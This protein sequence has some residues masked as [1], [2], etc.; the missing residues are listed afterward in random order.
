MERFGLD[1]GT[2]NSSL[3]WA[4]GAAD[5]TLCAL[6]QAAVDPRVLRSLLYSSVEARD[7]VVGQRAIDEYLSE[8]MQGVLMQS[9]KTFLGDDSFESTAHPLP[10]E[11]VKP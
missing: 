1:F 9:I 5:V 7:F 2:T 8:D 10:V 3:A 11:P 6:D 4:H